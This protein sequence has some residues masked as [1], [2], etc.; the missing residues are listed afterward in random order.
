MPRQAEPLGKETSEAIL[1][2]PVQASSPEETSVIVWAGK[3]L[4]TFLVSHFANTN[5][6]L[7]TLNSYRSE[8]NRNQFQ[9]SP[10]IM[11]IATPSHFRLNSSKKDKVMEMIHTSSKVI[12]AASSLPNVLR[13]LLNKALKHIEVCSCQLTTSTTDYHYKWTMWTKGLKVKLA[14]RCLQ[15]GS[16]YSRLSQDGK[17]DIQTRMIF[18]LVHLRRTACSLYNRIP[19][20]PRRQTGLGY[21]GPQRSPDSKGYRTERPTDGRHFS[22]EEPTGIKTLNKTKKKTKRKPQSE[23]AASAEA[24]Q[25]CNCTQSPQEQLVL[26]TDAKE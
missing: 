21:E 26:P 8:P 4:E 20:S 22:K 10:S 12:I 11:L 24:G 14:K 17:Q 19:S 16:E 15:Q 25:C 13:N 2:V 5:I 18:H 3:G 9:T 23:T 6:T 7:K 1:T